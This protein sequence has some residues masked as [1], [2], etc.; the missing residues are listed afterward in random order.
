MKSKN[1]FFP[2][3]NVIKAIASFSVTA[4]HFRNRIETGIPRSAL[5]NK[6]TLFFSIDYSLFI[7]AV[8]LFLLVT[9]FLSIHKTQSKKN[10]IDVL[11]IYFLFLFMSFT[12]YGL[13]VVTNSI[14]LLPWKD[15]L[16]GI[17]SFDLMAGWYIEL[18]IGLALLIPFLNLL[19]SNISKKEFQLLIITLLFVV[20]IPSFINANPDFHGI[21]L[22]NFWKNI[23]PLI[24]YFIGAYIRLY[25]SDINIKNTSLLTLYSVSTLYLI[26]LLFRHAAPYTYSVEGY[27]SSIINVIL[28]TSFFLLLFRIVRNSNVLFNFISKY[29]LTTYIMAYPIDM[30]LY[31]RFV[32]LMSSTKNLLIAA[33]IIITIAFILTILSGVILNKI[34]NYI[35]LKLTIIIE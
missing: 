26:Q 30:I 19:I 6:I 17:L 1:Q 18:Y 22:P 33:P 16:K 7:F 9:G 35:W 11:K 25:H 4:L 31:P 21:Y 28:A 10:F 24:Y 13:L 12:S 5:N 27:Y 15:V 23:Y 3:I 20:A 8:P 34:F 32:N 2:Q 29:T 14:D